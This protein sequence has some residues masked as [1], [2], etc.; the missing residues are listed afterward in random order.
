MLEA[1]PL[2]GNA[3]TTAQPFQRAL[4]VVGVVLLESRDDIG[5]IG[6]SDLEDEIV[7]DNPGDL[8]G[9][10]L[11]QIKLQREEGVFVHALAGTAQRQHP[12]AVAVGSQIGARNAV[13]GQEIALA[14]QR[15]DAGHG[16]LVQHLVVIVV[17]ADEDG[18]I[19]VHTG[20]PAP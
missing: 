13:G 9:A 15:H 16:V 18:A 10:P 19:R 20:V 8:P 2:E 4:F 3:R 12:V 7:E 11:F 1:H 17:H 14:A 5:V 6:R